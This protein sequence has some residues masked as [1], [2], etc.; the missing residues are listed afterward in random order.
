M[1][2]YS[3][4]TLRC[5]VCGKEVPGDYP[6]ESG[7]GYG[8]KVACSYKHQMVLVRKYDKNRDKATAHNVDR[9]PMTPTKK[10]RILQM[11]KDGAKAREIALELGTSVQAVYKTCVEMGVPYGRKWEAEA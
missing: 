4:H 7:Y 5:A 1:Q 9:M 11:R 10:S 8:K 6:E 2:K 3:S